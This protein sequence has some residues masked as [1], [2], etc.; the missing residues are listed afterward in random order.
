MTAETDIAGMRVVDVSGVDAAHYPMGLVAHVDDRLHLKIKYLPDLFGHGEVAAILDRV[1]HIIESLVVQS[2]TPI[3]RFSLLDD[4]ERAELVPVAGG[5]P[6]LGVTLPDILVASAAADPDAVAVVA[7]EHR[8]TYRELD[9]QSNRMARKLIRYG[10]GPEAAVAIAVRRSVES[11]LAV[12]A[13]AKTGAAFLPVDPNYPTSR[14]E[15][16]ISDSAVAVGFT[17]T[18]SRDS[19]P[20]TVMWLNLDDP[21][22]QASPDRVTDADRVRPLRIEHPAY[23][24]YTSGSTGTPKGVTVTHAGLANLVAEQRARFGV[25]PDMRVLHAASPSFDAAVLEMLWAFGSGGRLVISQPG[26]FGGRE[27]AELLAREQVT[28]AALTPAA[29]GTVDPVGLDHLGTVIVG[30]EACPPELVARWAPGRTMVNT[31]GPAEA[32]IQS[33]AGR[34]LTAGDPVTIGGPIRGFAELVLDDRLRPVPVGV[35]GELY[36]SGPGLARGYRN[37]AGLTASRFVAAPDGQRM[38]RTGDLVRWC[39]RDDG[40]L[41]LDY[42]GRSDQQVKVRGFRIELGEIESALRAC[43]GVEQAVASVHRGAVDRLVGYVVPEPGT[44][45][46]PVAVLAQVGTRLAPHMVPATVSVIDAVPVT[47]NGK[48]DRAA[49]PEPDFRSGAAE[50]RAPASET[51]AVLA[52]LFAEVLGVET[53]G[54]QDSFFALGGDSIMSIQLVARAKARGLV[55]SPRDVFE[56]RTVSALAQVAASGN[57]GA[58]VLEELPGGGVGELPLTP[59]MHWQSGRGDTGLHRFSQVVVLALPTAIDEETLAGTL[60]AVLDRH[61][62]LRSRLQRDPAAPNRWNWEA[63]PVGAI[64]ARDV[65]HRVVVDSAPGTAGFHATAAAEADAA[66]DRLDPASGIVVQAVWFDPDDTEIP[67]RLL[68]MIHHSAVDGVSWRILVPDLATAWSQIAAG[69]DPQLEAVGT[70]MRRWAHGLVEAAQQ[71]ERLA[72]LDFWRAT[73]AADDPTIG[74]RPLDPATD[75]AAT[76]GSVEVELSAEVTE[77]LLTTV[78]DAFH[79]SVSDGL[80]AALAVSLTTWRRDHGYP[81]LTDA[82]IGLEG[83]GREESVVPG[84]DLSRTVGWFS[85]SYPMRLDLSGFDLADAC[86]GGPNLGAVVKSVKEQ[87]LAVPDHGIG[88]GLLRHLGGEAGRVLAE[89]TPPQVAF[90]YLGRVTTGSTETTQDVPWMPVD[91]AGDLSVA[92]NPDL[93]VPAVLDVNAL[94][95]DDG[96]RSRLRAIWSFPTG[97]L[98]TTEVDAVARLWVDVLERIAALA[99]VAGGLTPSDLGLVTLE[100]AQIEELERR[101]PDLTDVWPLSPLQEGLLFHALVSEDSVDAYLVQLVLELRG[102]VDPQRL[103]RAGKVLLERHANLRTAFV[104]S[105]GAPS[106]QVIHDHLDVPFDTLDLSGSDETTLDRE[107]AAVMAADR[108]TRF[109]PA[110]APLIRW[111][112]VTTGPDSHRLVMTNHHL[113]LDGW[114]TPLLLKELLVLYATDGD[115]TMLPRSRSYR[116]FLAWIGE[117]DIETSLAAWARAFDG[118][119]EPTLVSDLDSARRYRESR[120][121]CADFGV[122]ETAALSAWVRDRGATLNT[123][124][125]V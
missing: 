35:V 81:A 41:E 58:V 77:A 12:W 117:Q 16:M 106:V 125:Q 7:G 104:R 71:P 78:P 124:V 36:L 38:Y 120:D 32:T 6:I 17:T 85:T 48:V 27:L 73:A 57:S 70:S 62:M 101:Y 66:A 18:G 88:F 52:E 5:S 47:A 99:T 67:G 8:L 19:L 115:D 83:H 61:D 30:G 10:I 89:C 65:L 33:N 22:E 3:D 29:L 60:Q 96:G 9:E 55:F 45:V 109:D 1:R 28:H 24:I 11:V 69:Q 31:Y 46:D 59:I 79:G 118:A 91:D 68:V 105:P 74:S 92:Q 111:L 2:N 93:P 102:T 86:E 42:V 43:D 34:P 14:I 76:T 110:Q 56:C 94:T 114:S 40:T 51:E 90:N 112:L 100:Q 113:L 122:E 13:V 97:M 80:V 72:E 23:V 107:F 84:V 64:R 63:L 95:L 82:V 54:A 108:A 25:G 53:V 87:L 20:A 39:R 75:T 4:A 15:H 123:V 21:Y 98:T 49:L 37:R 50:F 121:V 26:V 103:R 119:T 44:E 116:D